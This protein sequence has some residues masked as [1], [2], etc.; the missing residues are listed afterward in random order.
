MGK[1][2]G[3]EDDDNDV[4]EL[5]LLNSLTITSPKGLGLEAS[6]GLENF[7]SILSTT[8]FPTRLPIALALASN[9]LA[10]IFLTKLELNF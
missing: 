3:F 1:S 10:P 8:I 2:I 7:F 9:A 4:K 5:F 6:V